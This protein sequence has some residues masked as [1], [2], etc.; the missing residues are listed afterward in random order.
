MANYQ[1]SADKKVK[2][3]TYERLLKGVRQKE[4][5]ESFD[6]EYTSYVP[7][8]EEL[9]S[10]DRMKD[11][12]VKIKRAKQ[13]RL[14]YDLILGCE[15]AKCKF[16]HIRKKCK[17]CEKSNADMYI[18][19]KCTTCRRRVGSGYFDKATEASGYG[20]EMINFLIAISNVGYIYPNFL[21]ATMSTRDL[22][23]IGTN[24]LNE[25]MQ[26]DADFWK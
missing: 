11:I 7:E 25:K 8:T 2:D 18:V 13:K 22:K 26:D 21:N 24:Y 5:E 20:K 15:L 19:L 16:N 6:F 14:E 17:K 23:D 12:V 10:L 3:A 9:K 1:Q 4:P